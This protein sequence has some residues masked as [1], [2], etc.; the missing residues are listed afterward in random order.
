MKYDDTD[1]LYMQI[2]G[3]RLLDI[4]VFL[5]DIEVYSGMVEDAP[6]EVKKL[7]YSKVIM[8]GKQHEY[9]TYSKFNGLLEN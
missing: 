7:Y 5:D 4:K 2:G 3:G 8:N 9:Y 6:E 1:K